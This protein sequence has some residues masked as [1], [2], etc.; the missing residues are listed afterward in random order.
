[1]NNRTVLI[2]LGLA[3]ALI[4]L[5]SLG[6]LQKEQESAQAGRLFFPE[7]ESILGEANQVTILKAGNESVA[8]LRR[9][10]EAWTVAERDGYPADFA[11]FRS[12]LLDLAESGRFDQNCRILLLHLGGTPAVHAYAN[13][14]D[15]IHLLQNPI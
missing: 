7:L 11:K 6:S 4:L 5:A 1:M 8:T 12:G 14:F 2:L 9:T 15:P 3:A 13:Q 10:A